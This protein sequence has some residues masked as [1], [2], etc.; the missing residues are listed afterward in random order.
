[1][2][3]VANETLSGKGIDENNPGIHDPRRTSET[4][5]MNPW[6]SIELSL[7]TTVLVISYHGF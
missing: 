3:V 4:G 1:M 2:P 7:R 6:G 5:S